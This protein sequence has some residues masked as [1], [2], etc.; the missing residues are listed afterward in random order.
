MVLYLN[1]FI[2]KIGN[3]DFKEIIGIINNKSNFNNN[4]K[5]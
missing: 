3:Y 1:N 4:L 5:N 2:N